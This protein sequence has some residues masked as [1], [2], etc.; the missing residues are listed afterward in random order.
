MTGTVVAGEPAPVEPAPVEDAVDEVGDPSVDA[1]SAVTTVAVVDVAF[2]PEDIEVAVGTTVDWTNEDPFAHTV[3]ANDG[4]FDS[5]TMDAGQTFSQ[6]FGE[7]GTFDYFC[8]IHPSMTGTVTV[9]ESN[10][11]SGDLATTSAHLAAS[12]IVVDVEGSLTQVDRFDLRLPDGRVLALEPPPGILEELG[13]SSSHLREH[14]T[15]SQPITVT[16]VVQDGLNFV[17]GIGDAGE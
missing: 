7:P 2:E 14:M 1:V 5:G 9:S 3:T 12:G 13:F 11:A 17:T 8:A 10:G 15:L 16:Y 6:V 4:A